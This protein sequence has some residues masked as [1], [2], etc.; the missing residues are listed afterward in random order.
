MSGENLLGGAQIGSLIKNLREAV[1]GLE[2]RGNI[3]R[4]RSLGENLPWRCPG[5]AIAVKTFMRRPSC[6]QKKKRGRKKKSRT[7][8]CEKL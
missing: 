6:F 2:I 3:K 4:I 5:Q 8:L 7:N 1:N